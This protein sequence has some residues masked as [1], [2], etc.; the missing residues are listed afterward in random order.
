MNIGDVY[1]ETSGRYFP[2]DSIPAYPE[3]VGSHIGGKLFFLGVW[4]E[5]NGVPLYRY[6][7]EDLH[8]VGCVFREFTTIW[9]YF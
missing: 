6:V 3:C 8:L 4:R 9:V 5:E 1:I 7:L 2:G